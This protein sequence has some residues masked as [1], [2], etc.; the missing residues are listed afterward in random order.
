MKAP[1][2][3]MFA[4][5]LIFDFLPCSSATAGL[6]QNK[7]E[8]FPLS[9]VR[10]LD[11][12]VKG[13]QER[14]RKYLHDLD[15]GR[16]LH[17]FRVTAGLPSTAEPLAGWEDPKCELRGHFVGHY[18][19][20]C[21]LMFASTGDEA[22]KAKAD[23][24]VAE[25]AKC[26]E[27]MPSKGYNK[28][29]LSAY[30]E[31]F[32]D[33]VDQC[34]PVWAPYYTL[35]KIMAGLLDMHQLAGNLQALDVLT[36]MADWL[37]LRFG[38]LSPE[39]Q[40]KVL[41]NEHGGMNEV[42]ASLYAVTRNPE[43]L[44]LA[45][46]FNHELIFEPLSRGEDKLD[47]L[48]ANTQVPKII[49]AAREFELTGEERLSAIV[50]NFWQYVAIDRAY[51]IGGH[52]DSE[53]FFPV[54]DFARHLSPATAET[55]NTYNMLKLTQHVFEWKPD[56]RFMD[57]YERALFNQILASQDPD[58]GMMFYFASLKPGH[59]K[60]YNTPT[61]SFW[62]CTG[63][64]VENHAKYPSA[65]YAHSADSLYV[66]LFIPSELTW[67][68]KGVVVRQETKFPEGNSTRLTFKCAKPVNLT[69]K[70]R[71]PS[72]GYTDYTRE[73][74]DGDVLDFEF[75]MDLRTESLPGE[76]NT[77]AF[78][79]GPI[80]LAGKLGTQG[81]EKLDLYTKQQ[82]D[83]A[84]CP[85]PEV[86]VL[87][88]E[89]S[90]LLKH[91]EPV[92]GR[93]L[94]FRT[95]GIGRPEDVTLS[96]YYRLHHQR[97]NVYWQCFSEAEWQAKQAEIQKAAA[98][99]KSL[100]A[101]IVDEVRPGEPQPETDHAFKGRNSSNGRFRDRPWRDARNWFSYEVKVAPDQPLTLRCTYWGNDSGNRVFDILVNDQKIATQK[102]EKN[103]PGEFFDVD[104]SVPAALTQGK[105]RVTVKFQ[106]HPDAIVGGLFGL[107]VLKP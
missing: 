23:S 102:L 65:I 83:L 80:A 58:T 20:A 5:L 66:N 81:M 61:K 72:K 11:G 63:T 18:L 24:L 53:H 49:G 4:L 16:L 56:A 3:I 93:S 37:N 32:F 6:P 31:S 7:A 9:E 68:E 51:C 28:G 47:G 71:Q 70:M 14:D 89:P 13:A 27:A 33:R 69:I 94:T 36:K 15:A 95:K 78:F 45:R 86:P 98:A 60:N 104:Y 41:R 22:L 87:I 79:C 96:P 48:H 46:A 92:P 88:C 25:L 107:L 90:N 43:H 62:C 84:N 55:C 82:L 44:K 103:R 34:Q 101:R 19:S 21:A 17:N 54:R 74:K 64:G 35:H 2:A 106:A 1:S 8:F 42:L 57:F 59:F 26:Q 73:W 105:Q 77:V 40:Q 75:S 76:P 50:R 91:I 39:Q 10:L 99:R 52:S 85:A 38:K 30:P 67:K 12:V 29:F 100:E 97:L